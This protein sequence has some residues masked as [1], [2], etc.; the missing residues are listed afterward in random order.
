ML[1]IFL[2]VYL[3]TKTYVFCNIQFHSF[4]YLSFE[5]ICELQYTIYICNFEFL[6]VYLSS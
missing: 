1:C 2:C 6:I 4:E 3:C 5:Y